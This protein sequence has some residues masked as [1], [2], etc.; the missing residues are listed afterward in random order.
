MSNS[1]TI[2]PALRALAG[3]PLP[4]EAAL[5]VCAALQTKIIAEIERAG[6]WIGFDRYMQ[7]ALYEPG[8]GYYSNSLIK[9]GAAGDFITAPT[10]TPLFA[11]TLA[12]WIGARFDA[13]PSLP[14][15]IYEFGAGTGVLAAELIAAFGRAGRHLARYRIIEPSGELERVQREQINRRGPH[16][17]HTAIDWLDRLP[18]RFDGIVLANEVL[19]ALPVRLFRATDGA[20]G[21]IFERGVRSQAGELEFSDQPADA[22]LAGAAGLALRVAGVESGDYQSELGEQALAWAREIAARIGCGVLVLIDYGFERHEYYHPQRHAGTLMCHYRHRAHTDPFVLPGLQDISAH[23]E[24][25]SIG[26]ALTNAGL[27][28]DGFHTQAAFLLA[29]GL[30]DEL[31]EQ[32]R[33]DP[34]RAMQATHEVQQLT[35]DHEMGQLFKVLVAGRR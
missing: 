19:D 18:E 12:R 2:R 4:D 8:F 30:L 24:F 3:A 11:R 14:R 35:A 32:A 23:V 10:L 27:T 7:M 15:H 13:Q 29:H 22:A 17:I 21:P 34:R 31:A 16:P 5:D 26:D 9:F 6:G 20:R 25:S 28:V 1:S 33:A